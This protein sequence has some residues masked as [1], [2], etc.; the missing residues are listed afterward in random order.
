MKTPHPHVNLI[1]CL[2]NIF[3]HTFLP[4]HY[5]QY[6]EAGKGLLFVQL[7]LTSKPTAPLPC[8]NRI[9]S[10]ANIPCSVTYYFFVYF[11]TKDMSQSPM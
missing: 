10:L 5:G 2:L 6:Y 4:I 1:Y 7:E 9:G 3:Q 11:R 8:E